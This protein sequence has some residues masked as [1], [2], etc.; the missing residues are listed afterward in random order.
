MKQLALAISIVVLGSAT[1][2]AADMRVKAPVPPPA[3]VYS[4]TG[5]YVGGD[6]GALWTRANAVMDPLPNVVFFG[7]FPNTGSLNHTGFVGGL[8][9]GYNWQVAPSWVVG[10]EADWSWTNV[11]GSFSEPWISIPGHPL[12]GLRPGTN[13]SMSMDPNWL[14]T[15]RG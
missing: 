9:A 7:T 15:I 3:P 1:A 12:A 2:G 13:T 5:F 4:W 11:K 6:V 8:H 10:V 14:A